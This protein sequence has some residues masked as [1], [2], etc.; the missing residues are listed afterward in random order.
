VLLAAAFTAFAD[1]F[2]ERTKHGSE[3]GKQK[4]QDINQNPSNYQQN[5]EC[6]IDCA[7]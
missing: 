7:L 2:E 3:E 6:E 4:I 1:T 5:D